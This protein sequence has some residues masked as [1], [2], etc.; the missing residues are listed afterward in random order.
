MLKKRNNITAH[1]P[2]GITLKLEDR[3]KISEHLDESGATI[4]NIYDVTDM[5]I[6]ESFDDKNEA[7]EALKFWNI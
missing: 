3:Y 7:N 6:I 1:Y 4:Y 5:E 2:C